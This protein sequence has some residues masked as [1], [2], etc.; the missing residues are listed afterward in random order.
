MVAQAIASWNSWFVYAAL[1]FETYLRNELNLNHEKE[2][3]E[4]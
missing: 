2:S 4:G 1:V 3:F